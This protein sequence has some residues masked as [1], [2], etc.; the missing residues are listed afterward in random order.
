[1]AF[2]LVYDSIGTVENLGDDARFFFDQAGHLV[3]EDTVSRRTFSATAWHHVE[4]GV[5]DGRVPDH[6]ASVAHRT[7]GG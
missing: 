2:R 6:D 7:G 1:M 5:D 4:E 3:I